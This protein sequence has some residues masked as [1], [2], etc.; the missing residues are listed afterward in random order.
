MNNFDYIEKTECVCGALRATADQEIVKIHAWGRVRFVHC[1]VCG[2]WSQS[3]QI[4]VQSLSRW[5][6]SDQYQG[7]ARTNNKGGI[8][9]NYESSEPQ[10]HIEALARI[11]KDLSKQFS[12]P[13][14]V[15]EVGCAS[16]SLL[17]VMKDIGWQ[18]E[19]IDL[20]ERFAD[21]GQRLNSLDIKVGDFL[22]FDLKD[23]PFDLLVMLGTISNLQ[24]ISGHLRHAY[25]V[26]KPG[27][28]LYFNFPISGSWISRLYGDSYWM[29]TPSVST[30]FGEQGLSTIL[31]NSGFSEIKF[32]GDYQQPSISK[33]LGKA[34]MSWLNNIADTLSVSQRGF[35]FSVRIPGIRVSYARR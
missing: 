28:V 7:A 2:S 13:G 12:V 33:L 27:G 1:P 23:T 20:S 5:Y 8:Y 19:G 9:L 30:F 16:G 18:V 24:G 26:L 32:R 15:L 34:K 3:P 14:R 17:A 10:R 29:F 4:S 31:T 21:M 35:P 22:D 11:Q 25:D 6:D